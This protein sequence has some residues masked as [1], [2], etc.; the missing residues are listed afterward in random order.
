VSGK[1]LS[2]D[3]M[4]ISQNG[5]VSNILAQKLSTYNQRQ[6]NNT[7][8]AFAFFPFDTHVRLEAGAGQNWVSFNNERIDEYYDQ[9]DNPIGTMK[10]KLPANASYQFQQMYTAWVGDNSTFGVT[11]PFNDFRY[12]AEAWQILGV[13]KVTNYLADFRKYKYLRPISIAWRFLF[14]AR[15]GA[16]AETQ[17]LQPLFI[18]FHGYEHG[19]YGRSL[20]KQLN[21]GAD[22]A[23]MIGTRMAMANL[24]IRLPFS[25]PRRLSVFNSK[26]ILTQITH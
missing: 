17:A 14:N 25:G 21:N 11:S 5:K 22:I 6:F 20:D 1:K 8:D 2:D 19:F 15:N 23:Q 26:F 4:S 9:N 10:E 24:E 7:I 3:T 18:G 16:D 12:R 13:I